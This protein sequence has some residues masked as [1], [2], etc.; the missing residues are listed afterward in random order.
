MNPVTH[1]SEEFAAPSAKAGVS[2]IVRGPEGNLW[3]TE[4]G[5]SRVGEI[6]PITHATSDFPTPTAEGGPTE[7]AAGPEGNLWFIEE[8]AEKDR[9]DQPG[10]ARHRRLPGSERR[11]VPRWDR[12]GS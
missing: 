7:I 12:G 3:F 8:K 9:R 2:G 11:K 1:A 4:Y 5:V 10:D 6:D